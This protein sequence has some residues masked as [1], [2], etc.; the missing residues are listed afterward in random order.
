MPNI[1]ISF[2]HIDNQ[3]F[4]GETKGWITHLVNN[5]RNEVDRKM[6]RDN[7]YELWMDYLLKGSDEITPKIEQQLSETQALIILLS[8]GWLESEWCRRELELFSKNITHPAGRIFVVELDRIAKEKKPPILHDMLTYRFWQKTD[9]DKIRQLGYPIPHANDQTYYDRLADLSHDLADALKINQASPVLAAQATVYVAPVNDFLYTQRASLISELRQ[10]GIDSL[11]RNNVVDDNL[12]ATLVQ[13][14]HFVQLLDA[15]ST[16]GIPVNQFSAASA[17]GKPILQ[18]RDPKLNY[19]G[20]QVNAAQRKLLED[21]TVVAAPLADFIRLVREKVLPQPKNE[22]QSHK[23]SGTRM[24]FVHAGQD[25]IDRAR[26]VAQKLKEK[27]FGIAL[28]RYE[29]D[30]SLIRKTIERGYQLCDVLLMLQQKT[31]A[32]VVEDYLSEAMT[33]TLKRETKL[34]IMICQCNDAEE[35]M[36]VP[37]DALTLSCNEQFEARCLEQFLAEVAA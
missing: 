4:S 34:P 32:V 10:F 2:A 1:F 3:P 30:A 17:A 36:F 18:W 19:S 26:N 22:E 14:S 29:G 8:T 7:R 12:T 35:L 21:K 25:D 24:V 6:G 5:L 16:M 9:Q 27:G 13:C 37:P 28:P 15:N 31:S 20:N 11:P 33:Q 23:P